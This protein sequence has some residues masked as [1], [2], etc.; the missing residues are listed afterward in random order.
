[1]D[2]N[3]I[4]YD[5]LSFTSKVSDPYYFVDLLNMPS[6]SWQTVKGFYGYQERLYYDGISIH[7]NGRDDMGICCEMSGQGCRT[8]ESLTGYRGLWKDLFSVIDDKNLKVTRLDVAYDDHTGILDIHQ[9]WNDTINLEW[10][11]RSDSFEVYVSGKRSQV[12]S[13]AKSV[14][15]GSKKSDILIRIY[16][17]AAERHCEAGTHWIR[18]ELQL[19]GDRAASFLALPYDLGAA[20][21]GVL[22]NYLRYVDPVDTDSNCWRWPI[23]DYWGELLLGAERISIY[24]APGQEYNFDRLQKYVIGQAGNAIDAYIQIVGQDGFL[25]D[26]KNRPSRRNPKYQ[27]LVNRF[28][29]FEL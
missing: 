16:D 19:R 10:I 21:T 20:F 15:V 7:F 23:K 5:W 12:A 27:E 29:N 17:K 25:K 13:I 11:S 9:I 18:V 26:L 24:T 1:M 3:I 4:L 14:V 28:A 2:E 22:L 6:V 8:F